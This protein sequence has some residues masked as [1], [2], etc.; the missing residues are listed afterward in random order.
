MQA[1]DRGFAEAAGSVAELAGLRAANERPPDA[2]GSATLVDLVHRRLGSR[3]SSLLLADQVPLN[4]M[5]NIGLYLASAANL[6]ELLNDAAA[7]FD[8]V[9]MGDTRVALLKQGDQAC[10]TFIRDA[11]W[12]LSALL[13]TEIDLG[14]L[15]RVLRH[16][17]GRDF[18][19]ECIRY[20]ECGIELPEAWQRDY[21][22]RTEAAG[23]HLQLCFASAMLARPTAHPNPDI[24]AALQPSL[25]T[26]MRRLK[27]DSSWMQQVVSRIVDSG[28]VRRLDLESVS[29]LL[30]IN[31]NALSRR[32]A[33]ENTEFSNLVEAVC[34][35][36]ALRRLLDSDVSIA[37]LADELGFAEPALFE[38]RFRQWLQVSPAQLRQE[39][40]AAGYLARHVGGDLLNQLPNPSRACEVLLGL[41]QNDDASMAEIAD[42]IGADPV[43]AARVVGVAG[44]A[45]YGGRRIRSVQD[46]ASV[47]GL[48]ELRRLA[49]MMALRQSLGPVNCAHFDL[50]SYWVASL[51]LSSVAPSW[52]HYV[53]GCRFD[54]SLSLTGL[55]CEIGSLLFACSAAKQMDA[56]L[57][58]GDP[59]ADEAAI[60]VA[61]I[62]AF[63]TPRYALASLLLARWNV[64]PDVVRQVRQLDLALDPAANEAS[65]ESLALLTLGRLVRRRVQGLDTEREFAALRVGFRL[66]ASWAI[67]ADNDGL[68]AR[69]DDAIERCREQAEMML[70]G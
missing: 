43:L 26:E 30:A 58:D 19:P 63:G 61:E 46:A 55:L 22:V 16:C 27:N 11:E 56:H 45:L 20:P 67:D 29:A 23:L 10:L 38:R 70:A 59:D 66:P 33:E 65:L 64:A 32:L 5:G 25:N 18:R 6:G 2:R 52:L 44:S 9:R 51:V 48:N 7:Y 12:D 15:L 69:L 21:G 14:C 68:E 4:G 28:Q 3:D 50:Q 13:C 40:R 49:A 31:S 1:R 24:R 60:R 34:R 8:T 39:S 35:E 37:D 53:D 17:F 41:Q 47:L 62:A 54:D 42:I 36:H 57:A